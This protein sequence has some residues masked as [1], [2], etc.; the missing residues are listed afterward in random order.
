M[1]M[2]QQC[3]KM[4]NI[5]YSFETSVQGEHRGGPRLSSRATEVDDRMTYTKTN[6]LIP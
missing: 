2:S 4:P 6:K 5:A 3:A 1:V